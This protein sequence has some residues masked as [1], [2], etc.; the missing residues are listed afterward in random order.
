MR[1]VVLVG[2]QGTRLRPLTLTRPKQML[3]VA[4]QPMIERVL[5]HLRAHGISD[6]VLSLGYRPDAFLSAYPDGTCAGVGL[7]YAVEDHP[8]DTAGGI[9][10]AARQAGI[11]EPFVV[12]NG[13]VLTDLD[14]AALI[15]L[16]QARGAEATIALTPVADPS[17]F[18]VVPTDD[19]DRV[20]AFIEKPPRGE[21]P[22]N[23]INAGTYVLDPSVLDLIEPDR[24]TSIER[25]IF[26]ALVE[27][28]TLF[29]MASDVEWID[30]GTPETYRQANLSWAVRCGGGIHPNAS[31]AAEA[32]VDDSVIGA[33]S[34]IA[35]AAV[36]TG[37]VLLD[38][39][40][41]GPGATVTDAVIGYRSTIGA[42]ARVGAG[43]VLGDDAVIADGTRLAAGQDPGG[44]IQPPR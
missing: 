10:F 23:L 34:V 22:T 14:V 40:R 11:D 30:A 7:H 25:E 16:H 18:G 13:D 4:G 28:R 38:G 26:P 44:P 5:D 12:V 2:G 43:V 20:T 1:A 32:Q 9:A 27:R 41:I 31:L 37:S 42:G 3:P 21:A 24:K 33:G 8:L 29:A 6:V 39:V 35:G 36:V 15:K 17:A 19:S